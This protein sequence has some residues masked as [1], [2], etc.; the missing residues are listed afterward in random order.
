MVPE[1]MLASGQANEP[2]LLHPSTP[3]SL[4]HGGSVVVVDACRWRGARLQLPHA[5]LVAGALLEKVDVHSPADSGP[6]AL[7]RL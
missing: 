2:L 7:V 5:R 4:A 6:F 1:L 3:H